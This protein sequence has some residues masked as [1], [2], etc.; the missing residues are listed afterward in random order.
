[1][2][3][4]ILC[5]GDEIL[6][7]KTVNSNFAFMAQQLTDA[8]LTVCRGT[9][10]GDDRESLTQAFAEAAGR[11]DAVIVNGGLGPT[12]DD[13][14]QE[15]AAEAAG[16]PLELHQNWLDLMRGWYE[17]RGRTMPE[18]NTKQAMLP[19][20][21]EFIDNPI[22][23]A[24]GFAVDIQQTRFFFTPGVPIE[25]RRMMT[26]QILPRLLTLSGDTV[27][28]RLKRFHCFGLGESRVD[29]MLQGTPN[30]EPDGDVRLGFQ[31]HFPQ[32]EIKLAAAAADDESVEAKLAPAEAELRKRLGNFILSE[33]TQSLED[34]LYELLQSGH[35]SIAL[36]ETL[37]SGTVSTRLLQHPGC[38]TLVRRS[39][40]CTNREQ[41]EQM[42]E[43][44]D[45][46]AEF[47]ATTAGIAAESLRKISG[48]DITLAA[49]AEYQQGEH[50]GALVCVGIAD[51]NGIVT[52]QSILPGN[53]RWS[54]LGASELVLDSLRRH[55]QGLPVSEQ[56]D[57]E[58][59]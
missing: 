38:E 12:V 36:A 35:N 49:L 41:L 29:L 53:K 33:D 17:K 34:V 58:Q 22:G 55:L 48:A 4:E 5:T 37:T 57:F 47:S 31:T 28:T 32:L 13:L 27:K 16:V 9:T 1:M 51:N 10:V 6:T 20:G 56:I 45:Q 59:H 50:P 52:R 46:L 42:L 3:I 24:C 19:A 43:A 54:S 26:E 39:V 23:T 7:G 18:N 2:Q 21:A 40:V 25:M 11:A 15:V 30:V 8:G 14:S 44:P